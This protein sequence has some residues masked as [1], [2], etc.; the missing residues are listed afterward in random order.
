MPCKDSGNEGFRGLESKQGRASMNGL[1]EVVTGTYSKGGWR[2]LFA[3]CIYY[4]GL[5][6]NSRIISHRTGKKK[7]SID[8]GL[9]ERGVEKTIRYM[10]VLQRIGR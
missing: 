9:K 6:D 8:E 10:Y 4:K 7:C 5:G 2:K 1:S 3:M